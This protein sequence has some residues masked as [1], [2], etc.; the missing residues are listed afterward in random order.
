MGVTWYVTGRVRWA[1][2]LISFRYPE[3]M[4][5]KAYLHILD[6][7]FLFHRRNKINDLWPN[8]NTNSKEFS[9]KIIV[10]IKHIIWV[11]KN[12]FASE[13]DGTNVHNFMR[14]RY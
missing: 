13:V 8:I 14:G 9:N 5:S 10:I 6:L 1:T 2:I 11:I 7:F 12:K 3:K 4:F